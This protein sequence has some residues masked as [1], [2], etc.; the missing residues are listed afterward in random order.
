MESIKINELNSQ[1]KISEKNEP[2]PSRDSKNKPI[3]N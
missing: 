1:L 3:N 2:K